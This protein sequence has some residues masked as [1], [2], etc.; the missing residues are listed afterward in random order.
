MSTPLLTDRIELSG[1][2]MA[3]FNELGC[4]VFDKG[5]KGPNGEDLG[6]GGAL[7]PMSIP[8]QGGRIEAV[9]LMGWSLNFCSLRNF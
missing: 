4:K 5:K 7:M 1:T 8:R 6:V 9:L 3:A 2:F